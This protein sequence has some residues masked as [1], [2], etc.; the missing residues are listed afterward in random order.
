MAGIVLADNEMAVIVLADNEIKDMKTK[1]PRK[2]FDLRG[3][4][5]RAGG[6]D[7]DSRSN[8]HYVIRDVLIYLGHFT[9]KGCGDCVPHTGTK[10]GIFAPLI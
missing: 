1:K 5:D 4:I 9:R 3:R 7:L 2:P 8:I 6:S 10:I